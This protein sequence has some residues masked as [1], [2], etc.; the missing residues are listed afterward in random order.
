M[1]KP[2]PHWLKTRSTGADV[3]VHEKIRFQQWL[4]YSEL[5]FQ[6]SAVTMDHHH[7]HYYINY[8]YYWLLVVT[9]AALPTSA[10][11]VMLKHELKLLQLPLNSSCFYLILSYKEYITSN[12]IKIG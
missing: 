8:S 7:H 6:P 5:Q 10:R 12:G 3:A 11:H 4:Q 9:P 2:L 1:V